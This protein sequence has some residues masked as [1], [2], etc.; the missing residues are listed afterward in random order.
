VWKSG[1]LAEQLIYDLEI[2][3][4]VQRVV[5]GLDGDCDPDRCLSDV[6]EGLRHKSFA[7]INSTAN[8]YR[9]FYWHP[10]LFN[11]QFFPSWE[12]EGSKTNRQEA[13]RM[14]RELLSQHEYELGSELRGELDKILA[15][16]RAG[17]P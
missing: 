2:K 1:Y 3:D 5:Q 14:I 17:L 9:Q 6:M 10:K 4:H 8:T 11:R 15:E 13:H 12:G 7:G 16:A